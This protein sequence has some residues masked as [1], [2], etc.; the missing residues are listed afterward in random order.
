VLLLI[1][2]SRPCSFACGTLQR[3]HGC[4]LSKQFLLLCS[5]ALAKGCHGVFCC[6]YVT[7]EGSSAIMP[8]YGVLCLFVCQAVNRSTRTPATRDLRFF[9]KHRPPAVV[10]KCLKSSR[11]H[12][13]PPILPSH[14]LLH[15]C[16]AGE[17]SVSCMTT[18]VP[19][20]QAT[21]PAATSTSCF[22]S[23]SLCC[24]C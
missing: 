9:R 4:C 12:Q 10:S 3:R 2:T 7:V 11:S 8:L 14:P 19:R 16:L 1:N 18:P 24:A 13:L 23:Y 6:V 21:E 5:A 22:E 15:C 17:G 20:L